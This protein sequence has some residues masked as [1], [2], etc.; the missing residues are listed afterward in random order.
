MTYGKNKRM[1]NEVYKMRRV[2]IEMI[3]TIN[4]LLKSKGM[5]RMPHLKVRIAEHTE[6]VNGWAILGRNEIY[7]PENRVYRNNNELFC[8]VVHECLHAIWGI[9]HND[10]CWLM[11]GKAT[12]ERDDIRR[13]KSNV[14]VVDK[15]IEYIKGN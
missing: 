13:N 6:C 12:T 4:N 11:T 1:N 8:T 10:G 3:Y 5:D 14:E 9:E 2:I 7:F 15:M